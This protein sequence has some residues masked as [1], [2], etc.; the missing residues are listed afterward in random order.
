MTQWTAESLYDVLKSVTVGNG[1]C[2]YSLEACELIV[3]KVNRI[4]ALKKEHNAIVLAHSYV[5]PDIIRTVADYTGDSYYLSKMAKEATADTIVFAAVKFM[6]ET[7]KL[8]NP[9][10]QV[11][12]PS[13][14]N[15]CSLADSLTGAD[16]KKL[17]EEHPDYTFV[18]YINTTVDVKAQC[19]VCVTS[20]NVYD[21]CEKLP[22]DYVYFV[23]DQL[24]AKNVINELKKRGCNKTIKYTSGTCYV[25]EEYSP[26]M[27]DNVRRKYP[28]VAVIAHPECDESVLNR[29]DHVGSTSQM[30]NYVKETDAPYYF[31]LTECGLTSRL[32]TEVPDKV[33]VGT[34]TMCK[35]MKSNQLDH[36]IRV[37]ENP[38]PDD[39][40][41]LNNDDIQKAVACIDQMFAYTH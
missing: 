30:V 36:I 41:S 10:K 6:A 24:M 22:T 15:G 2:A 16:V 4:E 38:D 20:S 33:F 19:D 11:L 26:I 31:L 32:Q 35:Y 9:T 14:I 34:C 8:L 28:D 5:V 7:A 37:L 25:H 13:K 17:R 27:I 21:I 3:P 23:P 39:I 40:I 1:I 12:I 29:V 18:C